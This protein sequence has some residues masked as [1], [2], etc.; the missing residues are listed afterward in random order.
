[1]SWIVQPE[2]GKSS[3]DMMQSRRFWKG[4]SISMMIPWK[5]MLRMCQQ[6]VV[7]DVKECRLTVAQEHVEDSPEMASLGMADSRPIVRGS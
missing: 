4:Y 6:W 5:N 1:M 7:D 3:M 2:C